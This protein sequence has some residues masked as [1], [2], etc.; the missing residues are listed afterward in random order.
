MNGL[1]QRYFLI[2]LIRVFGR[3]VFH[4]GGTTRAFVLTDIPWP[5][6]YGYLEVTYLAFYTVY[7]SKGED[8]DVWVPADLDQLG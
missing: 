4:A 6:G 1:I 3:A 7:F 2:I 8:L 5:L